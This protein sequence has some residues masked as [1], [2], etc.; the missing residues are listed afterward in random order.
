MAD[1]T[2][3][4]FDV[5][6]VFASPEVQAL[7]RFTVQQGCTAAEAIR[8]SG[9]CDYWLNASG[10]PCP[11]SRFGRLIAPEQLLIAGDR[12][13]ILRP[14]CAD[15]KDQRHERVR[16]VRGARSRAVS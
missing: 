11:L 10:A 6:V 1:T 7:R 9:L 4:Q 13:E 15:P 5:E 14:L 8:A 3:P 16:A 2:M 12:V